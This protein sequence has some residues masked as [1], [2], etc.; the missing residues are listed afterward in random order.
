[1]LI[2]GLL[3][4]SIASFIVNRSPRAFVLRAASRACIVISGMIEADA[5]RFAKHPRR[6]LHV[7]PLRTEPRAGTV[8]SAGFT[9]NKKPAG[10]RSPPEKELATGNFQSG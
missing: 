10:L 6:V 3:A 4:G 1:M 2:A 9:P 5:Y 8:M 7:V